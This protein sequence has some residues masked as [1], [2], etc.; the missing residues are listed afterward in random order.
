MKLTQYFNR[1]GYPSKI[2]SDNGPAFRNSAMAEFTQSLRIAHIFSSP[3]HPQTNG[4][5][6]KAN[7]LL[8][9]L[10]TIAT[11]YK[12]KQWSDHLPAIQQVYN[13]SVHQ[14]TGFTPNFLFF[15]R[16]LR[17][18]NSLF[19]E[20]QPDDIIND[21][22]QSLLGPIIRLRQALLKARDN[23]QHK[24]KIAKSYYDRNAGAVNTF[25]PGQRVFLKNATP[26]KL[27]LRYPKEFIVVRKLHAFEYEI[28]SVSDPNDVRK[29][30]I[31]RLKPFMAPNLPTH[32]QASSQTEAVPSHI[33]QVSRTAHVPKAA[34]FYNFHNDAYYSRLSE[35]RDSS[36]SDSSDDETVV[37]VERRLT[38]PSLGSSSARAQCDVLEDTVERDAETKRVS[39]SRVAQPPS[40]ASVQ[41]RHVELGYSLPQGPHCVDLSKTAPGDTVPP[42]QTAVFCPSDSKRLP[43]SQYHTAGS[44]PVHSL[45]KVQ[46]DIA[47]PLDQYEAVQPNPSPDIQRLDEESAL[48]VDVAN[49]S[50]VVHAAD[51]SIAALVYQTGHPVPAVGHKAGLPTA[52]VDLDSPNFG[53]SIHS[54]ISDNSKKYK[55]D[56]FNLSAGSLDPDAAYFQADPLPR[57][58]N[59]CPVNLG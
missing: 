25:C 36:E 34:H 10:L 54:I 45:V 29:I 57:C 5:C 49:P 9:D 55:N 3:Y 8:K 12:S 22:D 44:N 30:N 46:Q 32:F 16:Q 53:E 59:F 33:S 27:D 52:F 41:K 56:S 42:T 39:I 7:G 20:I 4:Q 19:D 14:S 48:Q 31:N 1:Y 24:L 21:A 2:L 23:V 37:E 28:R 26:R 47:S 17:L 58:S 15:G 50:E 35:S 18:P 13:A 6:E 43:S 40:R 11:H 38:L 51:A